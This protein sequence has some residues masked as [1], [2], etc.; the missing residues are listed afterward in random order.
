MFE[1]KRQSFGTAYHYL[2]GHSLSF[3]RYLQ[4]FYPP[5]DW[6]VIGSFFYQNPI[7]AK[8]ILEDF[9]KSNDEKL[10]EM[11]R[12]FV[13]GK[14]KIVY[15]VGA[16][17]CIP[18][19]TLI[20]TTNGTI[21]IEKAR[22]VLSYNFEKRK[23]ENKQATVYPSGLKKVWKISTSLGIIK[24]SGEHKWYVERAG[25]II[26][27]QTKDI[28]TK[29]DKLLQHHR[30]WQ[31]GEGNHQWNNKIITDEELKILYVDEQKSLEEIS[32]IK[33]CAWI[34]IKRRLKR[35]NIE[36]R[37]MDIAQKLGVQRQS[38]KDTHKRDINS[39]KG[40]RK[41]YLEIA[42]ANF[43]WKCMKC[44]ALKTND[45]FDLIVHHKDCNNR[46]NDLSNLM[47]LCQPCHTKEHEL[48]GT[49]E[50]N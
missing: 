11:I 45:N 3:Q 18:K 14:S 6:R 17:N 2:N 21:P 13:Y 20:K 28:N 35:L 7:Q 44:G 32:K 36:I 41:T 1:G 46:N 9:Q 16:R 19:G 40:N 8:V 30:S 42:K 10:E 48:G 22:K 25:K 50:K 31:E 4:T 15:I 38:W 26:E 29:T 47:I 27:V 23:L 5:Y 37:P 12:V 43:E 24:C 49:H 39:N 34:T 33:C